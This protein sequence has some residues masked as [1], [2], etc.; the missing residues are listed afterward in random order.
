M[1]GG[2]EKDQQY[3]MVR[4]IHVPLERRVRPPRQHPPRALAILPGVVLHLDHV[5]NV[6]RRPGF[7]LFLGRRRATDHQGTGAHTRH[8]CLFAP[9]QGEREQDGQDGDDPGGRVAKGEVLVVGR[10]EHLRYLGDRV[11]VS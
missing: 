8:C 9:E 5:H 10:E 2:V 3:R 1:S 11:G 4:P 6:G 7:Q